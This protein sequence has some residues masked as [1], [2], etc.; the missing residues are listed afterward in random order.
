MG[1]KTVQNGGKK[2]KFRTRALE[3][4]F[5][6]QNDKLYPPKMS[7]IDKNTK[8]IEK[9][10]F[11][12]PILNVNPSRNVFSGKTPKIIEKMAKNR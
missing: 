10:D 6:P 1:S 2:P 12:D 4:P 7:K 11:L 9:I 8:F 3:S 5:L